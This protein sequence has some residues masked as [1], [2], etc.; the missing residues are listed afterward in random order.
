MAR[1]IPFITFE[2]TRDE[3]QRA[4]LI[5]NGMMNGKDVKMGDPRYLTCDFHYYLQTAPVPPISCN[6][7]QLWSGAD[8]AGQRA[9]PSRVWGQLGEAEPSLMSSSAWLGD[10]RAE[11]D[12]G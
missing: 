2:I 7:Y 4:E 10:P 9:E 3:I 1:S 6:P 5:P 11:L 12:S 8:Q